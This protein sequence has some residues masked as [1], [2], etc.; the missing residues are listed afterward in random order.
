M[1]LTADLLLACRYMRPK[2][3]FISIIT[4]LSVI[5]PMLGV[6]ILI[7]VTSVMA[8]FDYDIRKG[9]LGMQAHVYVQPTI[10]G[11]IIEDP[12]PLLARMAE[13]NM[14]G[15]PVIEGPVLIQHHGESLIKM[16]RG[17]LPA[18]EGKVTKLVSN[19]RF[20]GRFDI[21]EGEVVIGSEMARLMGLRLGDE[22]LLHAP[23]KL[24]SNIK[25]GDDGEVTVEQPDEIY[26]PEQV[27]VVG[28]FSMGIRD[29]DNGFIL[30]HLHQAASLFGYDWG[31]AMYIHGSVPDPFQMEE[32]L[33]ALRAKLPMHRVRRQ[34]EQ[35]AEERF[36]P[37]YNVRSWQE[38][39]HMLFSTLR[40]EKTLML[41]LLTFIVVVASFGITGTLITLA[42]QKTREIGIL[43]AMGMSRWLVA[44][45]FLLLGAVIGTLGT[46]LGTAAGL[47]VIRYR[48]QVADLIGRVIGAEVFP[49]ELYHLMQIPGRPM[50]ADVSLI[51][52]LSI[53]ICTLASLIPALYASALSPAQALREDN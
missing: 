33:A 53:L 49:A 39:N 27:E 15:A 14:Q 51:V 8:G 7:I 30:L 3:T 20:V 28:I 21:E 34:T 17:I 2:R 11:Q 18:L 40:V 24:T 46:A 44:R 47:L 38:E 35:G 22:L 13:A 29:F 4:L 1:H 16:G 31:S 12:K 6:A 25:W 50:L 42:V 43:K 48:N 23:Q 19:G 26:L 5:G 52:A 37:K 9:I 41:F 36:E 10:P 32:E 45:I